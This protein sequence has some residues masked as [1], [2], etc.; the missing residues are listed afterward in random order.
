MNEVY[1]N[2]MRFLPFLKFL[3]KHK[4]K[5]ISLLVFVIALSA[6]FLISAQINKQNHEDAAEIYSEWLIEISNEE[7][8]LNTLD[9]M[10]DHL[11]QDYSKTGYAQVALL[12]KAN[13]DAKEKRLNEA[14]INFDKLIQLTDGFRG[15]K[16]FNKMARVSAARIELANGSYEDALNMIERFSTS[17]T[18]AY[19]HELTGDILVKQGKF[20]LARNQYNTASDKY[21]DQSSISI[22]SMKIANLGT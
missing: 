19:I 2:N 12:T 1:D 22:V 6:Y 16:V 14:L 7:P 15:N 20:D 21:T 18:N 9:S 11:M 3:D 4:T 13:L 10:L 8:D 17:E 5:L